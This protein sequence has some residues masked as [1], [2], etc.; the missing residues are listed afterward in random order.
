MFR[1]AV[2]AVFLVASPTVA[3]TP[4][5]SLMLLAEAHDR[6]LV[7]YAVRLAGSGEED[8]QIYAAAS[9]GCSEIKA[10]RDGAVRTELPPEHVDDLL[11]ELEAAEKPNFMRVLKQI[12]ADRAARAGG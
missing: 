6:C 11:R 1:T 3:R 4:E 12:R 8:E 2:I 9:Q 10:R 5:P 7:T